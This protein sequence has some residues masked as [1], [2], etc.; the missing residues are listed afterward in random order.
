MVTLLGLVLATTF[1]L[2]FLV[3]IS[4]FL[5]SVALDSFLTWGLVSD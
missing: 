3:G 4:P 1:T 5:F 2:Y